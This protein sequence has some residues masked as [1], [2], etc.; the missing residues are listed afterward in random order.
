M[1]CPMLQGM[2][3]H[4]TGTRVLC[5]E[6]L[7]WAGGPPL[8]KLP[9]G[10][11]QCTSGGSWR[12]AGGVWGQWQAQQEVGEGLTQGSCEVHGETLGLGKD[13]V[14]GDP[15]KEMWTVALEGRAQRSFEE[16]GWVQGVSALRGEH[17]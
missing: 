1:P 9:Q 13:S 3:P 4:P 6:S 5:L 15:R 10:R 8:P 2:E 16:R 12:P 7:R 11:V 14:Q 17:V